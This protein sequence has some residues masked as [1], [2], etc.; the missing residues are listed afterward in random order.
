MYK[1]VSSWKPFFLLTLSIKISIVWAAQLLQSEQSNGL[2]YPQPCS[3]CLFFS[4]SQQP[5]ANYS[6]FAQCVNDN[7]KIQ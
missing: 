7:F 1:R 4:I 2:Q 6:I 3:P 5:V